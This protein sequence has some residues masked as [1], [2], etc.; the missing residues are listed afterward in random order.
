M[1]A[2]LF[3]LILWLPNFQCMQSLANCFDAYY[4]PQD[5]SMMA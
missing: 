1:L 3:D 2:D 5:A 4:L